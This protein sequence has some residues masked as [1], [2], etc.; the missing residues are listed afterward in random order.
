MLYKLRYSG[1]VRYFNDPYGITA[2]QM[3][4]SYSDLVDLVWQSMNYLDILVLLDNTI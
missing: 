3:T 4:S 2:G 1:L